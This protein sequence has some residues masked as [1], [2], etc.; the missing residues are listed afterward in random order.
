MIARLFPRRRLVL[1]LGHDA[2]VSVLALQVSLFVRL[3]ADAYLD[4]PREFYLQASVTMLLSMLAANVI[5]RGYRSSWRYFSTTDV[6]TLGKTTALTLLIFLPLSFLATRAEFVPRSTY[7]I[8]GLV[9]LALL[10]GPRLLYRM[11]S[12]GSISILPSRAG[13]GA[14]PALVIGAGHGADGFLRSLSRSP[15][16]AYRAVGILDDD[17]GR[18][19]AVIQGVPVLGRT[20]EIDAIIEALSGRGDMPH[21]LVVAEEHPSPERLRTLLEIGDRYGIGLARVPNPTELRQGIED[22]G[23]IRPIAIED[24]LGRPQTVLDPGLP[25]HAISG[26]RVLV[27]GAGGSIGSELA[28][29]IA[30]LA[31]ARLVLSDLSEFHLYSVDLEIAE[32]FPGVNRVSR[33]LDVRDRARVEALFAAERPDVVFHAAALKH[34]PIVEDHPL[35]GI[36]TNVL[37]TRNVAEASIGCGTRVMVLISTDKAVHPPN[38]MG[39]TKRLAESYCQA[40]DKAQRDRADGTRFVTVRFGNVLG[41]TGSVVPL[42]QRQL[43][44]GG[45]LTV[46]H[47]DVT[48]Y[49]MTISEAVALVLQAAGLGAQDGLPAGDIAVLDMGDPVRIADLARQMIRLAGLR[50]EVDI[51]ISFVGLRRGEKLHEELFYAAEKLRETA[52]PGVRLAEPRLLELPLLVAGL[53][54]VDAAVAGGDTGAAVAAL[55]ELVP[56]YRPAP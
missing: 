52:I 15:V 46:T 50:P 33:L 32:R 48:R 8:N 6:V 13:R 40:L 41:S 49:F 27:T 5:A 20:E 11:L 10:A 31:P 54:R 47:P 43:A 56:D 38:V 37:G 22:Q 53:V 21:K 42:F 23:A 24:L 25:R 1:A 51:K 39:A 17:S 55:A 14:V 26:K 16:P 29:Q 2:I 3:G 34:V 35:D 4:L 9:L 7:V 44:Q 28:R 36:Q 30:A 12:E 19:G 45:P 18:M